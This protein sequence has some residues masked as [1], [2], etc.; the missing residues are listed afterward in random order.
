MPLTK[1]SFSMVTGSEFNLLD[2]GA[3]PTGVSDSTNAIQDWLDDLYANNASGY[4]PQGTYLTAGNAIQYSASKKFTIRGA[5]KGGTI[6]KKYGSTTD[7]ILQF[8]ISSGNYLELNLNLQDFEIDGDNISGVNGLDFNAAA[9]V[10]IS[11]V[12]AKNCV[13]G[14]EGRGFLVSSLYDCDFSGNNYGARFSRGTGGSQPYANAI[15]I[16]GCRFN[17]NTVWGLYYGQGSGLYLRGCDIEANGTASD[18]NTG[19]VFIAATIDDE[20]GFGSVD[21]VDTW[22]E[23]NKGHTFLMGAATNGLLKMDTV[24]I[25][26]QESTRAITVGAIRSA[27]F[28]NVLAPSANAELVCAAETQYFAGNVFVTAVNLAGASLVAGAYKTA[29]D[30]GT[31]WSA[32]TGVIGDFSATV[33]AKTPFLK[34]TDGISEPT[35]DPGRVILFVDSADGDLKVKFGDGTVKTIATDT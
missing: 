21:V 18:T 19:G 32:T 25:Y 28:T 29:L 3:D 10:T 33:S 7:P 1:A 30:N 4:A 31:V 24:T 22:F 14:L 5:S 2:Y 13:V 27:F 35:T 15:N 34:L 16:N 23:A 8:T 17:G 26:A 20:T 11:R 12:R 9:L 6:F